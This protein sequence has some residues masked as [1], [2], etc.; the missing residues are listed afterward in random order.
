[1]WWDRMQPR[2]AD[3]VRRD[4]HDVMQSMR[5]QLEAY[6]Q[7][8]APLYGQTATNVLLRAIYDELRAIRADV[9]AI[10]DRDAHRT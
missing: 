5:Q 10:K 4:V 2:S 7:S 1:M 3:D 9:Q 8:N 6:K